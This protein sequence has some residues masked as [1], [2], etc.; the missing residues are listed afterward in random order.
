MFVLQDKVGAADQ[1]S[2][3]AHS[4]HDTVSDDVFHLGV[5]FLMAKAPALGLLHHGVGHGVGEVFLQAGG[6]PQ[7][8]S[9]VLSAKGITLATLG[10]AW[11]RVPVFVK[12]NGIGGSYSLQKICRP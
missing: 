8:F 11:V 7:H 5:V 6:Q 4:A 1:D 10:Q 2:F 9:F 3:S 12:D